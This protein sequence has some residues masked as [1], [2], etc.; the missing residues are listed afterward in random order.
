[1]EKYLFRIRIQSII[2]DTDPNMQ[3]I[4]DLSESGSL[5]TKLQEFQSSLVQ[6]YNS[7]D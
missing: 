5:P 2:T 1:M 4:S 7:I 3:I 6:K